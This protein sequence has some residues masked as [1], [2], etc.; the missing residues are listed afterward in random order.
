MVTTGN[1][2]SDAYARLMGLVESHAAPYRL[3]DHASEGQTDLVSAM[4]GH[5]VRLAAKCLVVMVKIGKK[6][7]RFVLAV[8]PGNLKLDVNAIRALY[9]ATYVGFA[10]TADAERLSGCVAGTV[11]PFT[12]DDELAII[13]D[14]ALFAADEMYFNAGRLDRSIMIRPVD[15]QRIAQPRIERIALSAQ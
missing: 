12:F 5:D 15:Y 8:I 14:P 6:V 9:C 7:T 13:A 10:S 3:I 1:A 2:G 11:L 4:R